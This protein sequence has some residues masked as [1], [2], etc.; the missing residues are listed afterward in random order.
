MFAG[1]PPSSSNPTKRLSRKVSSV[2]TGF[3]GSSCRSAARTSR[4]RI[5]LGSR[6]LRRR[7]GTKSMSPPSSSA[8]RRA[9]RPCPVLSR[10]I[11]GGGADRLARLRYGAHVRFRPG[12]HRLGSWR[13]EGRD[14]GGQARPQGVRHR[15]QVDGRGRLRQHWH[16]PVQDIARGG[17]LPDRHAA[18]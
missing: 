3:V 11:A 5:A 13:S 17:A 6:L 14:H 15:Q 7:S 10:S 18:S 12:G 2:P 8:R 9:I 1:E 16:D 4:A